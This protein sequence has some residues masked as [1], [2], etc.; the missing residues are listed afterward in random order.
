MIIGFVLT[1]E[2][3][4]VQE[5]RLDFGD[6]ILVRVGTFY[7]YRHEGELRE[8]V[9][10]DLN[11]NSEPLG[12]EEVRNILERRGGMPDAHRSWAVDP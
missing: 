11:F 5:R 1:V 2:G 8:A 4:T 6:D 12:E 10:P 3:D 9:L 7:W